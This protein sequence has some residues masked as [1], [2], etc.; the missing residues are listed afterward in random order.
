MMSKYYPVPDSIRENIQFV[1][2]LDVGHRTELIA[3]INDRPY[4]MLSIVDLDRLYHCYRV[5]TP[6]E[7]FLLRGIDTPADCKFSYDE[8]VL[9][10]IQEVDNE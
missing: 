6:L 4:F 1:L 5:L 2:A 9:Y 3:Y 10:S 8:A 7:Q